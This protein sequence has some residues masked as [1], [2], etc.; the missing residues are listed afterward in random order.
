MPCDLCEAKK[1]TKWYYESDLMWIADCK[2]CGIPMCV[3]KVHTQ[4]VPIMDMDLMVT[5]V[6]KIFG[7]K[8]KLRFQAKKILNHFHFHIYR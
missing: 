8:V 3:Y 7:N 6:C 2:S 4:H 5:R 1:I